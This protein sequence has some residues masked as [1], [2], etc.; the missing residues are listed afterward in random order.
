MNFTSLFKLNILTQVIRDSSLTYL[1]YCDKTSVRKSSSS[2]LCI[3][4]KMK[5]ISNIA[6]FNWQTGIR[7][8]K[9]TNYFP[10]KLGQIN[11]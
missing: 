11:F 7:S 2:G 5:F 1:D 6:N 10:S 4:I 9:L 3:Q 8:T